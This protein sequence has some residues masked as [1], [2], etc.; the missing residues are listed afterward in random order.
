MQKTLNQLSIPGLALLL[1]SAGCGQNKEAQGP[2]PTPPAQVAT[3]KVLLGDGT[4]FD[5]YP[6]TVVP[7]K[8]VDL[9]AMANGYVTGIYFQDGQ[10]VTKGQKL[11]QIDQQQYQAGNAQAEANLNAALANEKLARK[12]ADRYLELDKQDAIAK[13][14]VDNAV[15]ALEA[16]E[17]QANAA[18]AALDHSTVGLRYATISAPFSGTIG[19]SN[20]RLGALVNSG[21]TLLNS[22]STDDPTAVDVQLDQKEI[23]L[24][25]QLMR[26][27]ADSLFT[28]AL[29]DGSA[30]QR[31]GRV[32][33]LDRAVNPQTGTIRARLNFPNP[34]GVLRAGMTVNLNVRKNTSGPVLLIPYKA[35]VEQMG[36]FFVYKVQGDS[37]VQQLVALGTKMND[38]II[39]HSGLEADDEIVTEGIQKLKNGSK[40]EK[41]AGTMPARQ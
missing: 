1:F 20:V 30:Y 31:P 36:E 21:Q 16:A 33:L 11:Y 39:V 19:I 23:P 27:P 38:R 37:V 40:I 17:M 6:A 25:S 8:Q 18:R 15:A 7:L 26:A 34:D 22:V 9:V 41:S 4:Y 14:L 28:L 13:Q 3:D 10:K 29:P 32:E 12:N 2:P 5:S 24:F 35:V